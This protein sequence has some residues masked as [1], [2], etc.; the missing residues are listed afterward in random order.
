MTEHPTPRQ[1]RPQQSVGLTV[2]EMVILAMLGAV[3]FATTYVLQAFPNIHLL[4]LFIVTFTAVY[5]WRALYPIYIFV[6][7][8]GLWWGFPPS[9]VP[10]LYVWTVLWGAVMLLPRRMSTAVAA[11]VYPAVSGLH[12]L[13]FGVLYAPAQALLFGLDLDQTVTWLLTGLPYD[14]IHGVSNVC[15]GLLILPLVALLRRLDKHIRP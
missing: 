8:Y 10:Y 14:V 3:M 11:V 2:A 6:F 9:W 12:G 7:L 4:G 13:L 5:R 15:T 1:G